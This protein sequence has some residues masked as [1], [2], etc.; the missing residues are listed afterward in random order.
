MC[1]WANDEEA[2]GPAHWLS[3]CGSHAR[4]RLK[5]VF[6]L[7]FPL[8]LATVALEEKKDNVKL[9]DIRRLVGLSNAFLRSDHVST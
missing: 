7:L 1:R 4:G 6:C 3:T 8:Q 5:R 9:W 2:S